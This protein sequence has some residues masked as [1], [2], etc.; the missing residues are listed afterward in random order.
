MYNIK[1]YRVNKG[2]ANITPLSVKR[3]WMDD[4]WQSH[5]YHCFPV[6]LAN[7]LGWEFS[8]PE[9]IT[10]IWD[11]IS[12]SSPDHVKIITG[13]KYAYS[14]RANATISF[15]TGIQLKTDED[16]TMLHMP[17]PNYFRDGFQPFTTLMSSSF[18][19]GEFPL[20]GMITTPNKEI[21]IKANTPVATVI[22]IDLDKIQ[23]SEIVFDSL[24]N[25]QSKDINSKEYALKIQE[26]NS[27]GKWADFYRNAVDHLGNVIG[28]HQTKNIKLTVKDDLAE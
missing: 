21:T 17:T 9:D 7:K 28:R 26:L 27:V 2:Y 18:Y 16:I 12:D 1:A 8:F 19:Q 23:G 22:P 11:G 3:D 14:G 24:S 13:Q 10:F 20:V 6:S 15:H 25:R 5:A 4:T